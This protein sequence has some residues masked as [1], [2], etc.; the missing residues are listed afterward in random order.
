MGEWARA[1]TE[2]RAG[3]R[4]RLRARAGARTSTG[5]RAGAGEARTAE[6]AG[7]AVMVG[8]RMGLARMDQMP[9]GVCKP[10]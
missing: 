7:V 2:R 4:G 8:G 5:A 3:G 1:H 6:A 9:A 10:Q